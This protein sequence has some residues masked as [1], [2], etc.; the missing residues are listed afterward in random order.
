MSENSEES[1]R[2]LGVEIL[3]RLTLILGTSTLYCWP[4]PLVLLSYFIIQVLGIIHWFFRIYYSQF[5]KWPIFPV[6]KSYL[7]F[8][9][10]I[11]QGKSL[12]NILISLFYHIFWLWIVN[13]NTT[14][15]QNLILIQYFK[16]NL[17]FIFN[18]YLLCF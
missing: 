10:N 15:F 12:H 5:I 18:F 11:D 7:F 14:S 1:I 9:Q 3:I 17:L 8:K 6:I 16:Y 2:S 13:Q 4:I